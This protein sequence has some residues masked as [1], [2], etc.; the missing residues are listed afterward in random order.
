MMNDVGEVLNVGDL[1]Q[2]IY[3]LAL[4]GMH[5]KLK[6]LL[7]VVRTPLYL[8]YSLIEL[9]NKKLHD[10]KTLTY[11]NQEDFDLPETFNPKLF[12]SIPQ[13][14]GR[15]DKVL[16]LQSDKF[17]TNNKISISE[18]SKWRQLMEMNEEQK[19][20]TSIY[21]QSA[22]SLHRLKDNFDIQGIIENQL[23]QKEYQLQLRKTFLT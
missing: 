8:L 3:S 23:Y 6:L 9:S 17:I 7:Q 12:K 16:K 15:K 20:I 21:A 1:N 13:P 19:I 18:P 5:D 22:L 14:W 11:T 2:V 4:S 10:L